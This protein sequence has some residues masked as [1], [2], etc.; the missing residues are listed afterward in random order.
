ML[1]DKKWTKKKT[2]KINPKN[3][4]QYPEPRPSETEKAQKLLTPKMTK[5]KLLQTL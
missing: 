2:P 5:E 4:K 1:T 3:D